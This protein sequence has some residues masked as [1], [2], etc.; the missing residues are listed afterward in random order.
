MSYEIVNNMVRFSVT[1]TGCGVPDEDADKV[2]ERF[3]MVDHNKRGTGLGLHICTLI[4]QL[5]HGKVYL[6]KT[7]KKGA[8]FIFDHPI[9]MAL[10]MMF[11]LSFSSVKAETGKTLGM[12]KDVYELYEQAQSV[13]NP[14]KG[15]ELA[16]KMYALAIKEKDY[17]GKCYAMY[18]QLNYYALE[19]NKAMFMAELKPYKQMCY[20]T[21]NYDILLSAWVNI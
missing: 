16:N 21:G 10:I 3:Q 4:A 9:V 20:A 15:K 5:L 19:N 12:H 11:T 17:I 8:R 2:F 6:D 7:Y 14:A 18:V 13:F 1:D